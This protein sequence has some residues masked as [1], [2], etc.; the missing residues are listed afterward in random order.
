MKQT[1]K[2]YLKNAGIDPAALSEAEVN[3]YTEAAHLQALGIVQ[4]AE[5]IAANIAQRQ[6]AINARESA[7]AMYAPYVAQAV[8]AYH[9]DTPR[10]E[11]AVEIV[12][13]NCISHDANGVA[14]CQSL[15][16]ATKTYTIARGACTCEDHARGNVC[17]HRIALWLLKQVGETRPARESL[18][19]V[20]CYCDDCMCEHWIEVQG[21][22]EICHGVNF[23][24]WQ[25]EGYYTKSAPAYAGA[26]NRKGLYLIP[27]Y[28]REENTIQN[29]YYEELANKR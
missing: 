2:T 5:T 27:L 14:K 18:Y 3:A 15:T 7:R 22:K 21:K 26:G 28:K 1:V 29:D 13:R 17:K 25:M 8:S 11:R 20:K 24:P 19:V 9:L 12:L 16:D 4:S 6:T 23:T 10:V